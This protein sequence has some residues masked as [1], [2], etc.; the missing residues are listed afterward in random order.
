MGINYRKIVYEWF[1]NFIRLRTYFNMFTNL[2]TC[3][4]EMIIDF[5]MR[6]WIQK[7]HGN[8]NFLDLEHRA[9]ASSTLAFTSDLWI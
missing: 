1:Y 9:K 6:Y 8:L 4:I 5:I 7:L 2:L 3:F